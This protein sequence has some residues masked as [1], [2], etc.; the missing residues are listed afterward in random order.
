MACQIHMHAFLQAVRNLTDN[1]LRYTTE[2]QNGTLQ[3]IKWSVTSRRHMDCLWLHF[4]V[5]SRKLHF[6]SQQ[7]WSHSDRV[8][9]HHVFCLLWDFVAQLYGIWSA[10]CFNR[11]AFMWSL[12]LWFESITT[13]AVGPRRS[14]WVWG[15]ICWHF[16]FVCSLQTF[17]L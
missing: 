5:N 10:A 11:A 4:Q 12:S 16:W 17:T 3:R 13:G 15:D 2:L 14:V 7:L 6:W 1:S 8:P 9:L